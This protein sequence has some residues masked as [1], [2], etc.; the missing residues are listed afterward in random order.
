MNAL[1]SCIDQYVRFPTHEI[2]CIIIQ[3][4]LTFV[5]RK[6]VAHNVRQFRFHLFDARFSMKETKLEPSEAQTFHLSSIFCWVYFNMI[7]KSF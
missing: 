1:P 7:L 3:K 5:W 6:E 4:L 2:H